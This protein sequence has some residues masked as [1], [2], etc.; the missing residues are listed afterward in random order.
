MSKEQ[1][2]EEAELLAKEI[3]NL[4]KLKT[5]VNDDKKNFSSNNIPEASR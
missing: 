4:N 3:E 1:L 5:F 2:L